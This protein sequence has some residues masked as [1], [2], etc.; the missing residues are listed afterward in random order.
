M[1]Y[2]EKFL[3]NNEAHVVEFYWFS[4]NRAQANN[5]PMSAGLKNKNEKQLKLDELS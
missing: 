2:R 5:S 3:K 1:K 4:F